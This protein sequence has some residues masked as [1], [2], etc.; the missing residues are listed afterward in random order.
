MTKDRFLLLVKFLHFADNT[1]YDAND[2]NRDRLFKIREV[3]QMIN[4]RCGA[5]YYPCEDL[6][7]EF[8]HFIDKWQLTHK[9]ISAYVQ[10]VTICKRVKALIDS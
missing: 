1:N 9:C 5:V 2:P 3:C 10:F 6:S 8:I 7:V 4:D